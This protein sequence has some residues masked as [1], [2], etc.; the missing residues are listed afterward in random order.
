MTNFGVKF[1]AE[2]SARIA[3]IA[4]ATCRLS[5]AISAGLLIGAVLGSLLS[6]TAAQGSFGWFPCNRVGFAA[7]ACVVWVIEGLVLS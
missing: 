4:N 7:L 3:R 1:M 5:L 6:S 2:A